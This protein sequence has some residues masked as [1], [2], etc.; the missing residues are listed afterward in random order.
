MG[1]SC[2]LGNRHVTDAIRS[3]CSPREPREAGSPP[4]RAGD[5]S[6]SLEVRERSPGSGLVRVRG[7]LS[8]VKRALPRVIPDKSWRLRFTA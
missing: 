3:V 6:V 7:S 5:A 2:L 1:A 8:A 4:L